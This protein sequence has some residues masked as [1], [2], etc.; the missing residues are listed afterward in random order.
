MREDTIR[1]VQH[2]LNLS[3]S[4]NVHEAGLA[5]TRAQ[6]LML[7]YELSEVDLNVEDKPEP[8]EDQCIDSGEG[9]LRMSIWKGY[10]AGGIARGF[11]CRAYWYGSRINALGAP[12]AIQTVSYLYQY[13]VRELQE[14][15]DRE[16]QAH[17]G[18]GIHG[19]TW[20]Y[21]FYMGAT[22]AITDRLRENKERIIKE[23]PSVSTALMRI[24]KE[25]TRAQEKL[26][27]MKSR[28]VNPT[29]S[30]QSS[31]RAEG[32]KV[33]N[34]IALSANGPRLNK[35]PGLLGG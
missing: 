4:P 33:G 19:K 9:K 15:A 25:D 26:D 13:L 3:R 7:Y 35:A 18:S 1:K 5:A 30:Y 34:S 20:K 11:S 21:N 2:L 24:N 29:A 17:K 28:S 6:E 23:Q 31:A 10:L 12:S 16:W 22:Q 27:S 8:L 32:R 14:I